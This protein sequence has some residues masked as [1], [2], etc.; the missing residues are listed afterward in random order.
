[1]AYMDIS[2]VVTSEQG[3]GNIRFHLELLILTVYIYIF[4]TILH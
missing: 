1:M 2:L 4:L 3:S